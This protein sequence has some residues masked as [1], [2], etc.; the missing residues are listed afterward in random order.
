MESGMTGTADASP[1]ISIRITESL[2]KIHFIAEQNEQLVRAILAFNDN[3]FGDAVD[4]L[5][6]LTN[7][8]KDLFSISHILYAIPGLDPDK[9]KAFI[10]AQPDD[11]MLSQF[12]SE[13]D[14]QIPLIDAVRTIL[15]KNKFLV[16]PVKDV[17]RVLRIFKTCYFSKN[18]SVYESP[19]FVYC[20]CISMILLNSNLHDPQVPHRKTLSE[21]VMQCRRVLTPK[22]INACDPF[23]VYESINETPLDTS[24]FVP[25]DFAST[26]DG[27]AKRRKVGLITF[28]ESWKQEYYRLHNYSLFCYK[29]KPDI[30]TG[31]PK[32]VVQLNK[33]KISCDFEGGNVRLKLESQKELNIVRYKEGRP[34][35]KR[36]VDVMVLEFQDKKQRD[37]WF[38]PLREASMMSDFLDE[39]PPGMVLAFQRV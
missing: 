16:G 17:I 26:I 8:E 29:Q 36:G 19:E 7:V 10:L 38:Q 21:Y 30:E 25:E 14:L 24:F 4:Q 32:G 3:P 34:Y 20:H 15:S 27:Y 37:S 9:V 11:R 5:C 23:R 33:V 13:H 18:G 22:I 1:K 31:N 6:Q 39:P 35:F 2:D 12:L 28:F